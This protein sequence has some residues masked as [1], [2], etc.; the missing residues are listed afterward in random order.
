MTGFILFWAVLLCS[1]GAKAQNTPTFSE[2]VASIVWNNCTVCHRPGEIGPMPFTNYQEV[3]SWAGMIAYTTE[4]KIMPPWHP[5]PHFSRLANERILSSEEIATLRKWADAGAPEGDPTKTP[6]LPKFPEGSQLGTP[7]T[8]YFAPNYTI[9]ENKDVYVNFVIPSGS[10]FERFVSAIELVPD[11]R[12]VVHHMLLYLDTKGRGRELDAQTPEPGYRT[13]GTGVGFTD[14]GMIAGWVPGQTNRFFPKGMG[15]RIPKNADLILQIHYAPGSMG[16]SDRSRMHFF[17]DDDVYRPV[18]IDPTINWY[19][20][21]VNGPLDIPANTVKTFYNAIPN[22]KN[23]SL[24]GIAPHMHLIGRS[25]KVF[26][27]SLNGRDTIPLIDVPEWNFNWQGFYSFKK[28]IKIPTGYMIR[29]T[30]VYDNTPNNPFNPSSPPKRVKSGEATTD[31]M[32]LCYF[33]YINYQE[34]DENID[35]EEDRTTTRNKP[36]QTKLYAPYPNPTDGPVRTDLFLP[37]A[38]KVTCE[39]LDAAGRRVAFPYSEVVF[40]AGAG[41]LEFSL[42]HAPQG[43]YLMVLKVGGEILTQKI[44]KR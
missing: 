12:A 5:D 32:L 4:N 30:T 42:D 35:L 34:G 8:V 3:K 28:P 39:V 6:P 31:E 29:A 10:D 15:I 25:M 1:W 40:P 36:L 2:D 41:T 27:T 11:Q 38:E 23:I 44:V 13:E 18:T 37:K 33:T 9:P 22:T 14:D 7:D 16:K 26:A 21:M 24:I 19:L 43:N 17:Y 20:G